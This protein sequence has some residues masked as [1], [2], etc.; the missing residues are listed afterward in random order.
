MRTCLVVA[1]IAVLTLAAGTDRA[2]AA[3]QA[4]PPPAKPADAAPEKAEPEEPAQKEII[5]SPKSPKRGDHCQLV[6]AR[7]KN[8]FVQGPN[9]LGT[10]WDDSK[11]VG[12]ALLSSGDYLWVDLKNCDQYKV[13]AKLFVQRGPKSDDTRYWLQREAE[14]ANL[15]VGPIIDDEAA[16]LEKIARGGKWFSRKTTS[17]T[18]MDFPM[19]KERIHF[20]ATVTDFD[21]F[22]ILTLTQDAT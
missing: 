3:D 12:R 7:A 13:V 16:A 6:G 10:S 19:A 1:F 20:S 14:V 21:E 9:L 8:P 15:L 17:G 11:K 5:I 2:R 22:T 18:S 4:A